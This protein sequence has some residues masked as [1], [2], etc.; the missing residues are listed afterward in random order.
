MADGSDHNFSA[1][2][3]TK[4]ATAEGEEEERRD[5]AGCGY[6]ET[7]PAEKLQHTHT[8]TAALTAP[9]CTER[10]YTTFTCACGDQYVDDYVDAADHSY[11]DWYE[12]REATEE[13]SGEERRDCQNCD[14][15]ETRETEYTGS[16]EDGSGDTGNGIVASGEC[17][18]NLTWTLSENNVLTISG[19]GLMNDFGSSSVPWCGYSRSISAVVMKPGVTSIGDY[20]FNSCRKLSSVTIPDSVTDIGVHAFYS[21]EALEEVILPEGL[22]HIDR[23]A[24][25]SCKKLTTVKIPDSVTD[26]GGTVFSQCNDLTTVTI[27]SGLTEISTH[28]FWYCKNLNRIT[29]SGSVTVIGSS[30]FMGCDKLDSVYYGGTERAWN[31][32][33]LRGMQNDGN[34]CLETATVIFGSEDAIKFDGGDGTE[35]DPYLLSTVEQFNIV[36][37]DLAAW[38]LQTQDLDLSSI[39]E[40]EPIG[41]CCAQKN[42]D[43]DTVKISCPFTGSY[44]GNGYAIRNMR[45]SKIS[46]Q[47][48]KV[49][50]FGYSEGII[51]NIALQGSSIDISVTDHPDYA[52]GF[53][54][55]YVC[56]GGVVGYSSE[57]GTVTG[58]SNSGSIAVRSTDST[59]IYVGGIVGFGGCSWCTNY[60]EVFGSCNT[61]VDSNSDARMHVGGILGQTCAINQKISSCVNYGTVTGHTSLY[62]GQ[63]DIY[64]GGITGSHGALTSCVNFG[65]ISGSVAYDKAI[66]MYCSVGGLSGETSAGSG[67][68]PVI[69]DSV[70]FGNVYAYSSSDKTACCAGGLFGDLNGEAT[71]CYNVAEMIYADPQVVNIQKEERYSYVGHIIGQ[72]HS[73]PGCGISDCYSLNTTKLGAAESRSGEFRLGLVLLSKREMYA[74]IADILVALGLP[75]PDAGEE[76]DND[77]CI[78]YFDQWDAENQILYFGRQQTSTAVVTERTDA[79]LVGKLDELAG[80][81]VL[82]TV[83]TE[84]D[85]T[86]L[87]NMQM[88][89]TKAGTVTKVDTASVTVAGET[90]VADAE[91]L[92]GIAAGD[93]ILCHLLQDKVVAAEVLQIQYGKLA[94]WDSETRKIDITLDSED[95]AFTRHYVL[96]DLAGEQTKELLNGLSAGANMQILCDGQGFVYVVRTNAGLDKCGDNLTWHLDEKGTLTISGNGEMYD[97]EPGAAPWEVYADDIQKVVFEEGVT[98]IGKCAFERSDSG[99]YRFNTLTLPKSL[100]KIGEWAF[101]RDA[102]TQLKMIYF[103]GS[104]DEWQRTEKKNNSALDI[105]TAGIIF[106]GKTFD[107]WSFINETNYKQDRTKGRYLSYQN[108]LLATQYLDKT[109]RQ[110]Y[111]FNENTVSHFNI[112][113]DMNQDRYE[114]FEGF[115]HGYSVWVCLNNWGVLRA[116]DIAGDAESL[117]DME[118]NADVESAI[119]FYQGQQYLSSAQNATKA[120]QKLNNREQLEELRSLGSVANRSNILFLVEYQ[121]Y[122]DGKKAYHSHSVVG[123]ALDE[124]EPRVIPINGTEYTYNHRILIY[125]CEDPDQTADCNLYYNDDGVWCIKKRNIVSTSNKKTNDLRNN[126]RLRLATNLSS[127]VNFVDYKTSATYSQKD[128]DE[129]RALTT[130]ANDVEY[131]VNWDK[132]SAEISGFMVENQEENGIVVDI[133]ASYTAD[134][135]HNDATAT[136]FLPESDR[137]IVKSEDAMAFSFRSGHYY[138]N[139]VMD[140]SGAITFC[141]DGT[142]GMQAD[143]AGDMA[144]TLVADDGYHGLPWYKVEIISPNAMEISTEKTEDGIIVCSDDLNELTITATDDNGTQKITVSTDQNSLLITEVDD[145]IAIY[146][147]ADGNGEYEKKM[148]PCSGH[149]YEAVVTDP[150]CTKRG[151]TSYVCTVCGNTYTDNYVDAYG[152]DYKSVVTA[153][154]KTQ[155]GY[156]THTC[157]RC[158]DSYND[159]YVAATGH[160]CTAGSKWY[161]SGTYHYHQCT[162]CGAWVNTGYH[163]YA[164]DTCNVCGYVRR[165]ETTEP[166]EETMPEPTDFTVSTEETIATETAPM[167]LSTQEMEGQPDVAVS[168]DPD[169]HGVS[170]VLI[171]VFAV[172]ALGSLAGLTILLVYRKRHEID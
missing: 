2:Y 48:R 50:L 155:N 172:V 9:T 80:K 128:V 140:S 150:T 7:R 127:N 122:D 89:E 115:C 27:G 24:F 167:L 135:T 137:Y 169:N 29:I 102:H 147:D 165:A 44:D 170:G 64:C 15:F 62:N 146:V 118:L 21:C 88:V 148:E 171:V 159:S 157:T 136:A 30:A 120:F 85:T 42:D 75:V 153:P 93:Y 121:W 112:G 90:Y 106:N 38:Y 8:Y 114:K 152:H 144:L 97:Y 134:G 49:G 119:D 65:T 126:G 160:S 54:S 154:T 109:E 43:G 5:C 36:R 71:N 39:P 77:T 86:E 60:A 133:A 125:D 141:V 14:C 110:Q 20:A 53:F 72:Y 143:N 26:M 70:N 158:G 23:G 82:A 98:S 46:T 156:T 25:S 105:G 94:G 47:Y 100:K 76:E 16:S 52:R 111:T 41:Y 104:Y 63:N 116:S 139:A 84:N 32:M 73:A 58:C 59:Q 37:E 163:S 161:S 101:K 151:Y 17:G 10:G 19:E 6:F 67:N 13:E 69:R 117:L 162:S 113:G 61:H 145:K 107:V 87:I 99:K 57:H 123:Y 4:V 31:K 92:T 12:S 66:S 131:V 34:E 149:A 56:V 45:I 83:I 138:T 142:V 33:A 35:E 95:N 164:G 22:R 91:P 79:S 11:G 28:T 166:T 124:I 55:E 18:E 96:S 1:W 132:G 3:E 103:T 78:R 51:K 68:Y 108:Y 74:A 129:L 40:W 81:Y 168:E 130:S